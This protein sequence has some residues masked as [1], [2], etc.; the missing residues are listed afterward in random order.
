[1]ITISRHV[2]ETVVDRLGVK[3]DRV[4]VVHL[5]IDHARFRPAS[6]ERLPFLL[7]PAARWPH[8]NHARLFDAFALVRRLQ[9][10]LKLVLTG[11]GHDSHVIP[12]GVVV[13]G[14]VSQAELVSLYQT[15]SAVVFPSL[16]E[17]FGQPPLEAMA[18]GCPVAVARSGALPEVCG[19]AARYF[20]PTSS[21][22]IADAILDVLAH[23]ADYASRGPAQAAAF[24]W[25]RCAR[26]HDAIYEETAST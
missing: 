4:R 24:D 17:G 10:E 26:E 21:A 23:P 3:E 20:D 19:S 8:K 25:E 7:Y 13:R 6:G 16:Y 15:A 12:P 11:A 5:G 14:R 18:C 22:E 2:A 1:V 9:P